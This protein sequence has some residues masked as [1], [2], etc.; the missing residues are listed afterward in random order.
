MALPTNSTKIG[1]S[2]YI[3][4]STVNESIALPIQG[5]ARVGRRPTMSVHEPINRAVTNEGIEVNMTV[6]KWMYDDKDCT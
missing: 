1:H 3:T 5:I 4:K 2:K 6:P